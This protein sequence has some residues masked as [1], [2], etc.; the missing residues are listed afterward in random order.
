MILVSHDSTFLDNVVT[1]TLVFEQGEEGGVLQH[2]VGGYS[3]WARHGRALAVKEGPKRASRD[4]A[5]LKPPRQEPLRAATK[6]SYKLKLELDAF[7]KKIEA[8]EQQVAVLEART[9][10]P[11]FY[12][13]PFEE[14]APILEQLEA[15]K[16]S[17]ERAL[18]RWMELEEQKPAPDRG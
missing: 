7:P 14:V 17:L 1:S 3:D 8:L 13:Q 4:E 10:A 16:T 11:D 12:T 18:E 15:A 5:K 6:L 2:Y 9:A